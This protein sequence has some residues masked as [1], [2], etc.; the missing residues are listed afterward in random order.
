MELEGVGTV[1]MGCIL[2]QVAWKIND[3][4]GLK[5]AFLRKGEGKGSPWTYSDKNQSTHTLVH[6]PHPMHSV[7]E[8]VAILSV[9][10][11]SIHS[12]P[13]AYHVKTYIPK[14]TPVLQQLIQELGKE[15]GG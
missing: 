8:I 15:G 12:F 2:L 13:G 7:S 6:I 5:W 1:T 11:T 10:A 9:G 4:N 3:V 14:V